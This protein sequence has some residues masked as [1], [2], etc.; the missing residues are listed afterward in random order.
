MTNKEAF[1][2]WVE[3]FLHHRD[4]VTRTLQHID[5]KADGYDLKAMHS[6]KTVFVLVEPYLRSFP[7]LLPKITADKE[8][9]LF[10]FNAKENVDVVIDSWKKLCDKP[11]LLIYFVNLRA[12]GETYWALK[13]Y[14][15]QMVSDDRALKTGLHSLFATVEPVV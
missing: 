1:C 4:A 10:T 15:H 14:V 2:E 8:I 13:P 5:K 6:T 7:E 9:V 3:Q 11:K 12:A